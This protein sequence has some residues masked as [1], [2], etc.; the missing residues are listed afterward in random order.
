[1]S[2]TGQSYPVAF[3]FSTWN[4]GGNCMARSLWSRSC[5]V[6]RIELSGRHT[7]VTA[8]TYGTAGLPSVLDHH[9][10][11]PVH[12]VYQCR[13]KDGMNGTGRMRTV[14]DASWPRSCEQRRKS[15]GRNQ[16]VCIRSRR[17]GSSRLPS[18]GRGVR[19]VSGLPG[20]DRGWTPR[21]SA[22]IAGTLPDAVVGGSDL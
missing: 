13:G 17:S 3:R 18:S 10:V 16:S 21:R 5:H 20:G 2:P 1:M 15:K 12:L 11:H 22:T 9:F 7:T 6:K 14:G 19:Q 4:D 8:N